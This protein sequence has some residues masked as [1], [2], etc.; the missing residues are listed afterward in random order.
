MPRVVALLAVVALAGCTGGSSRPDS[1]DRQPADR[2]AAFRGLGTWVDVYDYL[3]AFQKPGQT[4]A[5]MVDSVRDMARLGV[6][7]LYLQAAQDDRR[8]EG[9]VVAPTIVGDF[10]VAAHR[11]GLR[12]VAWYLPHFADVQADLRRIEALRDFRSHGQRFDALALDIEWTA[13]VPDPAVRNARLVDLSRAASRALDA[14]AL[15]AIVLPPVLLEDVNPTLWPSFPWR[16]LAGSYD[17]WMPMSYWT[18]RSSSSPYRDAGRYTS[19]NVTRLRADIGGEVPVHPIGGIAD[20]STA[21]DD[22]GFAAAARAAGVI[23]WSMYDFDTTSSDAWP[24]LRPG[25]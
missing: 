15:G 11:A 8:S 3:P 18:L 10:L 5:V 2:I 22:D 25:A 14:E 13:D 21:N 9:D 12:V 24:R 1:R 6:K 17:V 20:G 4:P 16:Q 23:G 7:T 19:D